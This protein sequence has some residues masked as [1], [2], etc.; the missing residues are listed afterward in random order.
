[1]GL[2]LAVMLT[3]LPIAFSLGLVS[4]GATVLL[5]DT[6]QFNNIGNVIYAGLDNFALLA[7]PLFILM[8][9]VFS[10]TRASSDLYDAVQKWFGRLPGGL[11][12]TSVV[13]SAIFAA[14]CGSSPATAAAVGSAGIPEMRK[15]GYSNAVA[16][17]AIVAGGTLGILIPPSITLILYGIAVEVSIG[18]LFLGG[19]LP[20]VMLTLMFSMW[21]VTAVLLENRGLAAGSDESGVII[22]SYSWKERLS[23]LVQVIPFVLLILAVLGSLYGGIATPSESAG[24]GAII[25]LLLVTVIYRTMNLKK[26]MEILVTAVRETTM[27]LMII[28]FALV[29]SVTLSYLSVPQELAAAIAQLEISRWWIMVA[30][31]IFLLALGCFIP[32]AAIVVMTSPILYPIIM[33]LNF[34]PLWFGV[35]MTVNMEAGLITPPVGLNLYGVKGIAPDIPLHDILKGAIPYVIIILLA[36]VLLSVFPQVITWLPNHVMN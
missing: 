4:I 27:I 29:I 13:V 24:V 36:I 15:R 17:G 12:I 22:S 14:L 34:D 1:M 16:S 30:I 11:A 10:A 7:I 2:A 21:I 20:G 19:V 32:P 9:A 8:G 28:A 35:I 6:Y 33:V 25:A 31:N 5:L 23:S 18:K 26:L 3:G